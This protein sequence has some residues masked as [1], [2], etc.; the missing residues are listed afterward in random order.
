MI[1]LTAISAALFLG[2]T[3]R[4]AVRRVQSL[5]APKAPVGIPAR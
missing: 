1:S 5:V 4:V 2:W 3:V